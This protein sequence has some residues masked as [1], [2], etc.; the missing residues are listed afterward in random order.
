MR[1]LLTGAAGFIGFHTAKKLLDRGD[2]VIGIDNINDYYD[3]NLKHA[4]LE[5][6]RSTPNKKNFYFSKVDI[7]EPEDLDNIFDNYKPDGVIHL[8]AQAGVRYSIE[9]PSAYITSNIIGFQNI[10]E[11]C[12]K[13]ETN[14][15]V[16]ASS[17][18]VY[19]A[20]KKLPFS[21]SDSVDHPLSMYAATKKSNELMAHSYSYIYS[22]P[23]T[24][25][26]FFTVYGPWGRPDMALFKFAEAIM[27]NE[28]IFLY[29]HGKHKRDFTYVD[30]I[31][32][33]ILATHDNP[34]KKDDQWDAT[35][36]DPGTSFAPWRVYNIGNNNP[37]DLMEYVR[38]LE[39][40]LGKEARKEFLPLQPGDVPN[41]FAN[42]DHL[43]KD[44]GYSP[45]TSV[46]EGIRK[47]AVWYKDFYS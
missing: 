36:P 33:G 44:T 12:R 4:R 1:L 37:V 43:V 46:E 21:V 39:I 24:G 20:N 16:Y 25:L 42:I 29:N 40:E 45:S 30:D 47:F 10:L 26:R 38:I 2:E 6:I 31:V 11:C 13:H 27:K 18:S 14:H 7:S 23:T 15:L 5:Q 17:S 41:T 32:E 8:A 9:N 28:K 22:I 19:G 35:K 3:I 34:P